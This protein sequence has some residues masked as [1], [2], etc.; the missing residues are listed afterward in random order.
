MKKDGLKE[1]TILDSLWSFVGFF[2]VRGDEAGTQEVK[3]AFYTSFYL[4]MILEHL[5]KL[6]RSKT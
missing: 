5:A 4:C 3:V 1:G 2:S 6:S